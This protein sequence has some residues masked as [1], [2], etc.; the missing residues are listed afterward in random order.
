MVVRILT[1]LF[2]LAILSSQVE[3]NF[4]YEMK[5]G[6][7]QQVKDTASNDP[8]TS[9]YNYF[10]NLLD[11]N[12]YIGDNIYIYSQVEH[13][14]APVFGNTQSGIN[15]FFLEYQSDDLSMK[16]GSLYELFGRG[17]VYYTNYDQAIDYDNSIKGLSSNYQVNDEFSISTMIGKGDIHF[18]SNPS[19]RKTDRELNTS[20]TMISLLGEHQKIGYYQLL[21]LRQKL[22]ISS[23][24]SGI[25]EGKTDLISEL[26]VRRENDS[27]I[28]SIYT[29]FLFGNETKDTILINNLNLNW[30]STIGPFDIYLDQAWIKYDKVFGGETEGS[31]FYSTIYSEWFGTG[32][33]YEYKNYFTPYLLKS[34]S[35]P[36]IVYRESNSVLASRNTHSIN[37]GNEIGHQIDIN[38]VVSDYI[39]I[40]GNFSL[41]KRHQLN[42]DPDISFRQFLIMEEIDSIYNYSPFRQF[43][44]E[45]NG[46]TMSDR[47]YYKLAVD[48]YT[49]FVDGKNTFALTFPTQWVWKQKNGNSITMYLEGQS[50]VVKRGSAGEYLNS[51]L[52][53]S[54]SFGG[55]WIMTGF[56][57]REET[58]NKVNYWPGI[59]MTY[60]VNSETQVSLFYGS[61]KGGLVCANGICAEQPG[62]ENG[63]KITL[64]SLF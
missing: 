51:Y 20:V 43:Y 63:M 18:R 28:K 53:L 57:D 39:T 16:I 26:K 36:P 48:H 11:V 56:Y 33:T 29:D 47:L 64:R 22:I 41:S 21:G 14:D 46:W 59:D 54:Y 19:F 10:E 12:T 34:V 50:K 17:M 7:G 3:M 15:T 40:S 42:N 38:R 1:F 8:D 58:K 62:F 4:S 44:L 35:N 27:N 61:Q 25:F 24:Y 2:G 49:E 6:D 37:F 60:K 23:I 32:I 30:G 9:L 5:Y 55:K 13:S 31:R 52:S 45:A